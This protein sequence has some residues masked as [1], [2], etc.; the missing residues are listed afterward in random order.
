MLRCK[1]VPLLTIQLIQWRNVLRVQHENAQ[2]WATV[3]PE[4]RPTE[5]YELNNIK[6]RVQCKRSVSDSDSSKFTYKNI[7][8]QCQCKRRHMSFRGMSVLS[9]VHINQCPVLSVLFH[10]CLHVTCDC[11]TTKV[12][13]ICD[14]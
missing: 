8:S 14:H 2:H 3:T 12:I 9:P 7:L 6:I 4:F 10:C 5:I 1:K 11:F 13:Q